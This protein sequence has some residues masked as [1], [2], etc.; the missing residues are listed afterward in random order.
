MDGLGSP[1]L[2]TAKEPV[3]TDAGEERQQKRLRKACADFEAVF[4]YALLKTMRATIPRSGLTDGFAGKDTYTM[5]MDQKVAEELTH[6]GGGLGL[7]KLLMQQLSP[8]GGEKPP[9]RG[10]AEPG[11]G[12]HETSYL[13]D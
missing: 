12:V 11:R 9:E 6:R 2:A 5:I 7:Q 13:N 8:P 10:D 4:A 1:S 3:K